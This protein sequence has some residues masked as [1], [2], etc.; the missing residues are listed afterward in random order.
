MRGGGCSTTKTR[1][2]LAHSARWRDAGV[3]IDDLR[4]GFTELGGDVGAGRG[5]ATVLNDIV[6]QCRD[7]LVLVPAHLK[8]DGRDGQQVGDVGISVPLRS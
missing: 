7:S 2:G 1:F 8:D 3:R 6:E 4:D 5:P